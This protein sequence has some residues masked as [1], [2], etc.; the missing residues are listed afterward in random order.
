M[1]RIVTLRVVFE[2]PARMTQA[3]AIRYVKDAIAIYGGSME[4]GTPGRQLHG[5][6]A[7]VAV[8][9]VQTTYLKDN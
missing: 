8:H 5:V 1:K 6:N 4:L 2:L 3:E 7:R 9:S